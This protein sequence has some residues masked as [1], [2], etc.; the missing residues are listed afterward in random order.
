MPCATLILKKKM[1]CALSYLSFNSPVW[2]MRR[3]QDFNVTRVSYG[4]HVCHGWKA[5]TD[6]MNPV[7]MPVNI[8]L[9]VAIGSHHLSFSC[10]TTMLDHRRK[11]LTAKPETLSNRLQSPRPW[12]TVNSKQYIFC[13]SSPAIVTLR[14]S[15][16]F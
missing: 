5:N 4:F 7:K 16:K 6:S 13:R 2:L 11:R 8:H 9:H 15:G 14:T 10:K 1:S 3:Q 12:V